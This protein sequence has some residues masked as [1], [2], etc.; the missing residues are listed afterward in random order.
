M[1]A[2]ILVIEDHVFKLNLCGLPQGKPVNVEI[3]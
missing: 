2:R 3:R 1:S